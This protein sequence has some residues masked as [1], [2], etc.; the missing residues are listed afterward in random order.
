M[1]KITAVVVTGGSSGIGT[2][3]ITVLQSLIEY[4]L[5]CNLSRTEP[6]NNLKS[7]NIKHFPCDLTDSRALAEAADAVIKEISANGGDGEVLVINNSGFGSSGHFQDCEP[8]R[9]LAMVDL[10]IRAVVDLTARLLPLLTER[11]GGVINI[12][13]TAAW[14]PTP[15]MATY[16]ATKAFLMSWTLA[17][18]NDLR[19]IGVRALCVCP[20]PTETAFF[21]NSGFGRK[22]L[23]NRMSAEAVARKSLEAWAAGRS[24]VV[25]GVINRL[26]VTLSRLF[27]QSWVTPFSGFVLR[28]AQDKQV[29]TR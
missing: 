2:S 6:E 24:L 12:A 15:T 17:L 10:N 14:Q 21:S 19:G 1:H 4:R 3:L 22:K 11:G 26:M 7:L 27:P 18:N 13:S 23:P 16:G 29:A 20:G 25:T 5:I 9:Q 8:G 28:K